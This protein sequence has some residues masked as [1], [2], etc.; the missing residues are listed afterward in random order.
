MSVKFQKKGSKFGLFLL[1]I[2]GICGEEFATHSKLQ[3]VV[4][5]LGIALHAELN[6]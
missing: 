1:F 6:Y 5:S 3:V 2:D 4:S